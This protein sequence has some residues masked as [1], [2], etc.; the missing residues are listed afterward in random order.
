LSLTVADRN[1]KFSFHFLPLARAAPTRR[2]FLQ[3][4]SSKPVGVSRM[5]F[6]MGKWNKKIVQFV[7]KPINEPCVL[8]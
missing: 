5:D 4:V 6:T 3:P 7:Q 1:E 8:H 2:R